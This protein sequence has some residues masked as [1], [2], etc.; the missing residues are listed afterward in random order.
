MGRRTTTVIASGVL[1]TLLSACG[2][3]GCSTLGGESSIRIQVPSAIRKV[4]DNFRLELCQGDRCASVN[5]PGKPGS[6][7]PGVVLEEDA[8]TVDV[9][10]LGKRW[11]AGTDSGLTLLGFTKKGR[12]VLRHTEQFA[13]DGYYPNG[14]D[15]DKDPFVR[16]GTSVGGEDLV[17]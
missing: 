6:A 10:L 3:G 11:Q 4:V 9:A 1:M 16:H 15:C 12:T 2:Q 17:D 13:F 14:K 7:D 8:Y 5:F